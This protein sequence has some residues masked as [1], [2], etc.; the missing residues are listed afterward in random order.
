MKGQMLFLTLMLYCILLNAQSG[1]PVPEFKQLEITSSP[2]YMLLGVQP[3]NI[4]RPSTPREFS[5]SLNYV[6][7]DGVLQPSF[8]LETNPLNWQTE[9]Q[10]KKNESYNFDA[11]KYFDHNIFNGIK[12]NFSLSIATSNTDSVSLGELGKGTGVGL[13]LKTSLIPGI[14]QKKTFKQYQNF[15]LATAKKMCLEEL[16]SILSDLDPDIDPSAYILRVLPKIKNDIN[17]S[18]T[19]PSLMKPKVIEEIE[20]YLNTFQSELKVSSLQSRLVNEMDNQRSLST[21]AAGKI[22]S[23]V[24]P[25]AREGFILELAYSNLIHLPGNTWANSTLAKYGFWLT[26]SYRI[27][28][29]PEEDFSIIESLDVMGV[30]RYI[31]NEKRVDKT[32]YLDYG[33]KLQFNRENWNL[34]IEGVTRNI[35]TSNNDLENKRTNSWITNFSYLITDNLTFR[36]SFGSNFDG[37]TRTFSQPNGRIIMGGINFGLAKMD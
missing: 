18:T 30:L 16:K 5:T 21:R 9:K 20:S 2:A 29:S 1:S 27:D 33:F 36:F 6:N 25:F 8:A 13:G 34:S 12:N 22:D 31:W 7:I 37:T 4:S 19:I 28:L 17:R 24:T 26:P 10:K 3:T 32:N 15:A 35:I 23:M 11:N 14:V